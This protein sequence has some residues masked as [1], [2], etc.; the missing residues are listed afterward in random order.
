M[1]IYNYQ[2]LQLKLLMDINLIIQTKIMFIHLTFFF[3]LYYE[4]LYKFF[5]DIKINNLKYVQ[6]FFMLI[7]NEVYR[8]FFIKMF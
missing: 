3:H 5:I 6:D 2:N 8:I 7:I 4:Q 1:D